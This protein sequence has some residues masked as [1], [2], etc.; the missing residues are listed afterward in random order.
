MIPTSLSHIRCAIAVVGAAGVLSTTAF[1]ASVSLPVGAVLGIPNPNLR[2][3]AIEIDDASGIEAALFRVQYNR[4]I[5]VATAVH[6]TSLSD[7]CFM[8]VNISA[9]VN[10]VQ[11]SMAC[12][13]TRTGSGPLFTIDFAGANAG[14]SPLTFLECNLNEGSP[15]CQV[16]HGDLTVTTCPLNV[17]ASTTVSAVAN[18][19]GVYLFR[20]LQSLQTIVPSTFRQLIPGIP[21]DS[22]I[23]DNVNALRDAGL[24]DVD[25][26]GGTQGN[27]DGVYIF[28]TLPPRL[29]DIVPSNFRQLDPTIP[30]DEIIGSTIDALCP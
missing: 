1:A 9:P 17:D 18:T 27:T 28:R 29:Q 6:A 12:T 3:V 8:E 15:G 7:D 21:E 5:A 2:T 4:S 11:I 14:E 20:A 23:L 22:V 10:E 26:R 16:S 30:S 13:S 24:L 25:N 19:D